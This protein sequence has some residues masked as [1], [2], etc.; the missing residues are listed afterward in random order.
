MD[1][2]PLTKSS[3]MRPLEV[4]PGASSGATPRIDRRRLPRIRPDDPEPPG[5]DDVLC[6]V[7]HSYRP[8][9]P[10]GIAE[11][12]RCIAVTPHQAAAVM[13]WA[14]RNGAWPY[15]RPSPAIRPPHQAAPISIRALST[16]PA[17]LE[18]KERLGEPLSADDRARLD[19]WRAGGGQ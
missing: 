17:Y 9:D 11:V 10:V 5:A 12:R 4:N 3:A 2:P 18:V 19:A 1:S 15:R 13:A 6:A 14:A 16:D 7:A 8:D